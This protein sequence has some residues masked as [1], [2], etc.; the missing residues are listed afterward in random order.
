MRYT[1]HCAAGVFPALA[2]LA[3]SAASSLA[4]S[5]SI[6]ATQ[7][8][9]ANTNNNAGGGIFDPSMSLGPPMGGGLFVGSTDVHSLGTG[10]SL[11]LGFDVAV[12]DVERLHEAQHNRGKCLVQLPEVDVVRGH[13]GTLQ[14]FFGGEGRA[15]QHDRGFRANI[16]EGPDPRARAG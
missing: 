7:V 16:G 6:H 14:C 9:D 8:I 15:R 3:L 11:T 5:P 10:G 4:Q 2:V 13:A 12:I 1:H